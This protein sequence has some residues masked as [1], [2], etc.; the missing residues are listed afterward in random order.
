MV[1]CRWMSCFILSRSL[2]LASLCPAL[3]E[4]N[5]AESE[6]ENEQQSGSSHHHER[7]LRSA[8][9]GVL[10]RNVEGRMLSRGRSAVSFPERLYP[11]PPSRER[12]KIGCSLMIFGVNLFILL[13]TN[14]LNQ[15]FLDRNFT[16]VS[17]I[18]LLSSL[19]ISVKYRKLR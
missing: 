8:S 10:R 17:I 16:D 14:S 1:D 15:S 5:R 11:L 18:P 12:S 7:M 13:L 4:P 9:A 3:H 6:R 2:F 19:Y